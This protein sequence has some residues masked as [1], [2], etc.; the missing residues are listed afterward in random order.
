V[1]DMDGIVEL[2]PEEG[3]ALVERRVQESLR[4]SLAEFLIAYECDELDDEDP[5]VLHIVMLLP[6]TRPATGGGS[7]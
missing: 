4:M 7:L 1:T 2:S 5:D 3:R 6:F